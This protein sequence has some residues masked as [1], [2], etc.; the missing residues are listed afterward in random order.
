MP[1]EAD[2]NFIARCGVYTIARRRLM[3]DRPGK[4]LY[5]VLTLTKRYLILMVLQRYLPSPNVVYKSM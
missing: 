3:D 4:I 5:E 1:L 2:G